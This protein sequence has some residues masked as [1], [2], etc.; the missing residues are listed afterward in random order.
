MQPIAFERSRL[1]STGKPISPS[2][3]SRAV[4]V[5]D[6]GDDEVLLAREPDVA[7]L[8]CGE[9][10]DGEHLVA[11]DETEVHGRADGVHA[12]LVLELDAHVVGGLVVERLE[13]VVGQRVA[14]PLARPPRA[15]PPGR[16][17]RP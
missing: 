12:G 14:E 8:R 17:R 6:P 5:G 15:C 7:A 16:G 2:A 11:G 13:R 9:V 4:D 1:A 3:A 10:G